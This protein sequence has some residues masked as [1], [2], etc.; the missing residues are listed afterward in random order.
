MRYGYAIGPCSV[1]QYLN[2]LRFRPKK[3]VSGP[4]R[5]NG[6]QLGVVITTLRCLKEI[7]VKKVKRT[8][9][10]R[11]GPGARPRLGCLPEGFC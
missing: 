2:L 5:P 11:A 1:T 10:M 9:I 4:L 7:V 6:P 3:L 8:H